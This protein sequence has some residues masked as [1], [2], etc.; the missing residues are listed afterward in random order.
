[1]F[2][3]CFRP[4]FLPLLMAFH[5]CSFSLAILHCPPFAADQHQL[6]S[7]FQ[8]NRESWRRR[9]L[10][11]LVARLSARLSVP[12]HSP[13]IPLVIGPEAAT[14]AAARQLLELGYHVSAAVCMSACACAHV[15]C[16]Y[17]P[18]LPAAC[19]HH[20]HPSN[21][22]TEPKPMP[23]NQTHQTQQVGAIRPPTVPAGTCRL[24]VSLSAAHTLDDVDRLADVLLRCQREGGWDFA[25]LE[26]L[27]RPAPWS[28]EWGRMQDELDRQEA[29]AGGSERPAARSRL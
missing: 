29:A 11:S 15:L 16:L 26:H 8:L 18:A 20:Q 7:K 23:T 12:A 2:A 14:M 17:L 25:P 1:V 5:C 4:C 19:F 27:L 10:W 13:V 22:Q 6:A 21:Q 3:C 9:H 28:E 24:R